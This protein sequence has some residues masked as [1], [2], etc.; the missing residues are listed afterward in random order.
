MFHKQSFIC[1]ILLTLLYVAMTCKILVACKIYVLIA[2]KIYVL[3][4][5][6]EKDNEESFKIQNVIK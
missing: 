5:T 1:K 6:F 3:I 2:C 4:A